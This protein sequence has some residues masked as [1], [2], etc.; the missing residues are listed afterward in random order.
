M[1]AQES[2]SAAKQSA[3][4]QL[5]AAL[6]STMKKLSE[7]QKAVDEAAFVDA[8]TRNALAALV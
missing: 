7:A 8:A 6:S 3:A 5:E 2:V 4:H 1:E